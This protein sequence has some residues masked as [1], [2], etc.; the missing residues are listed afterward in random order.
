[1]RKYGH[2]PADAVV[3]DLHVVVLRAAAQLRPVQAQAAL[4]VHLAVRRPRLV[5]VRAHLTTQKTVFTIDNINITGLDVLPLSPNFYYLKNLVC[6]FVY[7]IY[8]IC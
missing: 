7:V 1:M 3:L 5:V 4:P 2:L 8:L 6:N